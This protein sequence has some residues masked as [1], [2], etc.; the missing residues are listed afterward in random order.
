MYQNYSIE[1]L[2]DAYTT[3]IEY[4]GKATDAM[5]SAIEERGGIESF[6]AQIELQKSGRLEINRITKEVYSLSSR[7]TNVEFI[8][9]LITSDFLSQK[10]L[11]KLIETKFSEHQALLQ[12]KAIT[13][14]TIIGG[15]S[16]AVI[17]CI[18]G[19][20]AFGFL[21]IYMTP[22][23]FYFYILVVYIIN[24]LIIKFITKQ[25]RSNLAV[26]IITFFATIGSIIL[27][28][29]FTSLL[30]PSG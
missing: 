27:G 22:M 15:L 2:I 23:F 24:Y 14:K 1:D 13:S 20:I 3:M 7:E 28:L 29:Y 11:D 30:L 25:S 10:E 18:I 12:N 17:S 26:F 5:L 19:A 21:M 9:N 8:K 16:G 4:S 6:K